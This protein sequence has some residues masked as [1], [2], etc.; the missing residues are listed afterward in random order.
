MT[1]RSRY[2]ESLLNKTR[3][4]PTLFRYSQTL[5]D[6]AYPSKL[7]EDVATARQNVVALDGKEN[8]KGPRMEAD[9]TFKAALKRA[10][11]YAEHRPAMC[12]L[13]L[14]ALDSDMLGRVKRHTDYKTRMKED[15]FI[16]LLT[17]IKGA[18]ACASTGGMANSLM[19]VENSLKELK[20]AA[21][22]SFPS[23]RTAFENLLEERDYLG[24]KEIESEEK[25]RKLFL[26]LNVARYGTEFI[27]GT[28]A[29]HAIMKDY[30]ALCERVAEREDNIRVLSLSFGPEGGDGDLQGMG[31]RR[32]TALQAR[33]METSSAEQGLASH[34]VAF[35]T[36]AV[37]TAVRASLPQ[38]RKDGRDMDGDGR[39]H[40]RQRGRGGR[41]G[42]P[43][44]SSAR[45]GC[46]RCRGKT[47]APDGHLSHSTADCRWADR[48]DTR[49]VRDYARDA[50]PSHG[51]P[52]ARR[53]LTVIR[54]SDRGNPDHGAAQDDYER[55]RSDFGRARRD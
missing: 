28:L 13:M 50:R 16:G 10:E 27:H 29:N 9:E 11:T 31:A 20:Q 53:A 26:T 32:L 47:L 8:S 14:T 44:A 1:T 48:D 7:K 18:A 43:D 30:S 54:R 5:E 17:I 6:N 25:A 39:Q 22:T 12:G 34:H 49:E 55:H 36:Q 4:S 3:V 37:R 46:D 42:T 38:K 41:G 23:H 52:R 33:A 45:D 21:G 40:K 35:I 2:M 51:E 24:G 15:D 19:S